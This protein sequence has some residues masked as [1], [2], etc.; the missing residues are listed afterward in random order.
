MAAGGPS[1]AVMVLGE[2]GLPTGVSLSG[3]ATE[4]SDLS[5]QIAKILT[6]YL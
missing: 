4:H 2:V 1:T 3:I 5:G 6:T